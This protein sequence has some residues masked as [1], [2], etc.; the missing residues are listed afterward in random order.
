LLRPVLLDTSV[1]LLSVQTTT[2]L[3]PLVLSAPSN[4]T[5]LEEPSTPRL[6][7]TKEILNRLKLD[8]FLT[9]LDVNPEWSVNTET[10]RLTPVLSVTG[11]P[12]EE[13]RNFTIL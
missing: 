9:A 6:A 4:G 7:P 5:V 3:I 2:G 1:I 10:E 11:A 13:M 8:K 12:L